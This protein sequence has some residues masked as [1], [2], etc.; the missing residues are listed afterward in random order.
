MTGFATGTPEKAEKVGENVPLG[1]IG[2]AED[3][4]GATLYLCG[5][6]GAYV[7]GAILPLD[8]GMSVQT[9]ANLFAN[10]Q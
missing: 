2:S 7:S 9:P 1:R 6:A 3:I 8:G 10:T 4:A 5:R